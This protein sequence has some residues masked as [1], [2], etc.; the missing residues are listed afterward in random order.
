MYTESFENPQERKQ[1]LLT[2]ITQHPLFLMCVGPC[3][4]MINLAVV[5]AFF[6]LPS[7]LCSLIGIFGYFFSWKYQFKGAIYALGVLGL[8]FAFL[9]LIESL[10]FSVWMTTWLFLSFSSAYFLIGITSEAF[11][12]KEQEFAKEQEQKLTSQQTSYETNLKYLEN[13]LDTQ[14]DVNKSLDKS[15]KNQ[16]K[17]LHSLRQ[18][19]QVSHLE[20]DQYKQEV[21][22]LKASIQTYHETLV[23]YEQKDQEGLALKERAKT[24]LNKLNETRVEAFQERLLAQAFQQQLPSQEQL[25]PFDIDPQAFEELKCLQLE[26]I[27][28]K[29]MYQQH[30]R[31]YQATAHQLESLYAESF[32][33]CQ[34]LNE[35]QKQLFNDFENEARALQEIR[36]DILKIEESILHLRKELKLSQEEGLSP[37]N[38]L[39]IADQECVRLEEENALLMKLLQQVTTKPHSQEELASQIKD[40]D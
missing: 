12:A 24:L 23:E 21:A 9:Y 10:P 25:K 5:T 29:Q 6:S 15:L 39:A 14:S 13:Q 40:L 2:K 34:L 1:D 33:E 37:G 30:Y 32:L 3:F 36:L 28:V 22:Q 16:D 17:E 4:L 38:Y 19:I 31:V 35:K 8:S 26:K 7:V 11:S 18:L 27:K 20:S